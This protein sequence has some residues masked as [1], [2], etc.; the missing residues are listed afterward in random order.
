GPP[1]L[2]EGRSILPLKPLHQVAASLSQAPLRCDR[3]G[4]LTILGRSFCPLCSPRVL[5]ASTTWSKSCWLYQRLTDHD[6]QPVAPHLNDRRLSDSHHPDSRSRTVEDF[7]VQRR[8]LHLVSRSASHLE[9]STASHRTNRV[10]KCRS[11]GEE[12]F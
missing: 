4:S 5:A 6:R 2:V 1:A 8:V 9:R 7:M 11:M 3:S 12:P 10:N